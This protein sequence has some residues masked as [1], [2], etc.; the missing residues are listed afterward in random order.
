MFTKLP[1]RTILM[2]LAVASL[3]PAALFAQTPQPKKEAELIASGNKALTGPEI[4]ALLL[5]NTI[6]VT[7][8]VQVGRAT[9]GTQTRAYYR[10]AK[11][12]VM[13]PGAGHSEFKKY[14]ANWWIEG[15]HVCHE[16]QIATQ[17]HSCMSLYKA[18]PV[19]YGCGENGVCHLMIRVVPGNPDKL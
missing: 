2:G 18:S 12:R 6:Y 16:T 8:L 1:V 9:P 19:V 11:T 3:M 10:D 15:D 5:G 14:E 7:F 13:A 4:N 17:G